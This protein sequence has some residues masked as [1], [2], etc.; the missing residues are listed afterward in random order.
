LASAPAFLPGQQGD[1]SERPTKLEMI[2]K[3]L[4][5]EHSDLFRMSD[6]VLRISNRPSTW[7]VLNLALKS[8]NGEK[9]CRI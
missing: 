5:L 9:I 2:Q 1:G 6:F 8:L 4:N 7:K 3:H